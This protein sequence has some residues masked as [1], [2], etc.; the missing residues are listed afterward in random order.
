[1]FSVCLCAE[2][3]VNTKDS[4]L[5]SVERIMKCLKGITNVGLWY[6]KGSICD[7]VGYSDSNY[8]CCK[9]NRK[10]TS[11]TYHIL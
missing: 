5:T 4:H 7:L 6:P 11:D 3:Q 9:T 1:M 10:S 2:F 8:A